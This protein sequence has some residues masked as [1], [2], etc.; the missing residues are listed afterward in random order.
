MSTIAQTYNEVLEGSDALPLEEFLERYVL[1]II[2]KPTAHMKYWSQ[3]NN[4]NVYV[5][6]PADDGP[7][8][9]VIRRIKCL[10]GY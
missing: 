1:P 8:V 10:A 9:E 3:H 5:Y 7:E 4:L 2:Y 6:D